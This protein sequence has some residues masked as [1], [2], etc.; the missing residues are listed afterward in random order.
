MLEFSPNLCRAGAAFFAA[1]LLVSP[2]IAGDIIPT[3]KFGGWDR[4][5]PRTPLQEMANTVD[6]LEKEIDT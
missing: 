5:H 6:K 1:V 3:W 2:L 4:V